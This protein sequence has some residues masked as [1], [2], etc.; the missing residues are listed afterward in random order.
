MKC[1]TKANVAL[2]KDVYFSKLYLIGKKKKLQRKYRHP[3]AQPLGRVQ[4]IVAYSQHSALL[5]WCLSTDKA[6]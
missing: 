1:A 6:S 3:L 5:C 2:R 4:E